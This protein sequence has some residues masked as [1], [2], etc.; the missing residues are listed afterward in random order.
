VKAKANLGT[1]AEFAFVVGSEP[2]VS[3]AVRWIQ[4]CRNPRR[5]TLTGFFDFMAA[6]NARKALSLLTACHA[7]WLPP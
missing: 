2:V 3:V 7:S 4:H 5:A 6:R 1:R